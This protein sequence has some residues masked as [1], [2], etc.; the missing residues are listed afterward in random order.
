[1]LASL[2]SRVVNS[3]SALSGPQ[4]PHSVW[5]PHPYNHPSTAFVNKLSGTFPVWEC[6]G[7]LLRNLIWNVD[8]SNNPLIRLWR[9]FHSQL[10][11]AQSSGHALWSLGNQLWDE[12][13]LMCSCFLQGEAISISKNE[14]PGGGKR[15]RKDGKW[16]RDDASTSLATSWQA[17]KTP[18]Q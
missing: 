17:A 3:S 14:G 6:H 12:R 2:R 9:D 11:V 18:S 7:F 10:L 16:P 8:N 4:F 15:S 13:R 5:F 1:M